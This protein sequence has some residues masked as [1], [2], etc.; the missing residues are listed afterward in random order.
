MFI[1]KAMNWHN[2]S[3]VMP[4]RVY[5]RWVVTMIAAVFLTL[6]ASGQR[7]A[8]KDYGKDQGLANLALTSLLQDSEGFLWVGTKAGLF[9]YDGQRFQEFHPNDP[10]DRSIMAIHQSADGKLW[11]AT[12]HGGLLQ[13]RGDHLEPVV[14][15]ETMNLRGGFE[16][17]VFGSDQQGRLYLATRNGL[18]R[19]DAEN[20]N[21]YR[22]EW[23][24]R[25]PAS[26]VTVDR[27]GAL[28]YG[29]DLDLSG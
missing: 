16:S 22:V 19:L 5:H 18:V 25:S 1:L 28:W 3:S 11:I 15:T 17:N 26:G 9:R 14:L 8:F 29:C 4:T 21:Q 24:S 12:E 6:P 7:F 13:R 27:S 2:I 23:L 20:G 10:A